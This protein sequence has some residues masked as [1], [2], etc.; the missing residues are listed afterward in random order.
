MS[1]TSKPI[2]DLVI[3]TIGEHLKFNWHN[4]NYNYNNIIV[5]SHHIEVDNLTLQRKPTIIRQKWNRGKGWGHFYFT[6][7]RQRK[8]QQLFVLFIQKMKC[9]HYDN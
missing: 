9:G 2:K 7:M 6:A 1:I 5:N 3:E 4:Y 8:N